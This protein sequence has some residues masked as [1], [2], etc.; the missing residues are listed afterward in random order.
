MIAYKR[1]RI[2]VS[3]KQIMSLA[4]VLSV[5]SAGVDAHGQMEDM[6]MMEGV[7]ARLYP[8]PDN[9]P[10]GSSNCSTRKLRKK[11][12]IQ[13]QKRVLSLLAD[14]RV[15]ESDFDLGALAV[16]HQY[17]VQ[18]HMAVSFKDMGVTIGSIQS[19]SGEVTYSGR[20][21]LLLYKPNSEENNTEQFHQDYP[22]TL[23]GWAYASDYEPLIRPVVPGLCLDEKDWF[24][25]E[26][27]VHPFFGMGFFPTPPAEPWVGAVKGSK[28]FPPVHGAPIGVY[29]GRLWDIHVFLNGSK[30]KPRIG[31]IK[32]N[33]NISGID[34]GVGIA[35]K[36]PEY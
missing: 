24:F 14:F 22:M 20:P 13:D 32:R 26:Q 34:S 2:G 17:A 12:L 7:E 19:L 33:S 28:L 5:A 36:Y 1:N 10:E 15:L 6:A 30:R 29:H 4:F 27:G 23:S 21:S 25:H 8:V 11:S 16:L 35:F 3:I 18:P 31:Q 9:L